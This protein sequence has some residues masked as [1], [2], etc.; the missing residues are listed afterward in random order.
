MTQCERVL[1]ELRR[2]GSRGVCSLTFIQ[3]FMPRGA[4]RIDDLK[5]RGFVIS[6]EQC[7]DEGHHKYCRYV[8]VVDPERQMVQARLAIA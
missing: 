4:A 5:R 1:E 6:S 7:D 8:L 2:A 3:N